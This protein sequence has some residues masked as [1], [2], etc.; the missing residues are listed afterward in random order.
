M[1]K[2]L[3]LCFRAH[4][5]ISQTRKKATPSSK[6]LRNKFSS[7]LKRWQTEKIEGVCVLPQSAVDEVE[8]LLKHV[9][10]GCLS[11]IQLCGHWNEPKRASASQIK[12]I[13]EQKPHGSKLCGSCSF[14]DI[15]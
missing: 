2:K 5:D 7:F 10:S 3:R 6:E 12:K 8:K 11:D 4:D 9:R 13:G 1:I 14:P 15:F